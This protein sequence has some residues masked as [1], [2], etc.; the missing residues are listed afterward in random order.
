[1]GIN[2][3]LRGGSGDMLKAV[4]DP[5]LDDVIA[6]AQL[7]TDLMDKATYD[8]DSDNKVDAVSPGAIDSLMHKK[9]ASDDLR[10]AIA[11]PVTETSASYI[12][13]KTLTFTVGFKGTMRI[14]WDTKTS[15]YVSPGAVSILTQDG[16]TPDTGH[17]L[18]TVQYG[19][20]TSYVNKTQDIALDIPAGETI[21]LWMKIGASE[22]AYVQNLEF[23]YAEEA[24]PVTVTGAD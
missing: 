11:A 9:I 10:H 18:G 15:Y 19:A 1:M 23:H 22:T 21:D 7:D 16:A 17:N 24:I 12:K 2:V 8:T 3:T 5:N 6:K 4:Y 13:K 14:A 20:T